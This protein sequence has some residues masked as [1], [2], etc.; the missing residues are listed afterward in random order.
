MS[1]HN[2]S[3][4]SNKNNKPN[5]QNNGQNNTQKPKPVEK[6]SE[7]AEVKMDTIH[8]VETPEVNMVK[9]TVETVALPNTVKGTV[10]HCAKLNVRKSPVVNSE[11][12]CVLDVQSEIEIDVK[13]STEN[14]FYVCSA[15]GVEGYCMKQYIDARM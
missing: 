8:V 13:K 2:Y 6:T 11:I 3:Q 5:N 1:K 4:Y 14:W 12:V 15:T 10:A 9:E 7:V